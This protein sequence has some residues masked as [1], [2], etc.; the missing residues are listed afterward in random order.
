[1]SPRRYKSV[2]IGGVVYSVG[3]SVG[4]DVLEES[5]SPETF[6]C[7]VDLLDFTGFLGEDLVL[8]FIEVVVTIGKDIGLLA[9]DAVF[10]I[11]ARTSA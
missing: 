4:A 7:A 1:M 3:D 8:S 9:D 5:L 10:V 2:L 6:T 11:V